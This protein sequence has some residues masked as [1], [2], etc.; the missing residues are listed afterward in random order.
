MKKYIKP[1]FF[2]FFKKQSK[3]KQYLCFFFD[4]FIYLYNVLYIF[5]LV[6]EIK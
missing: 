3:T 1:K 2:L 4:S 5:I 6:F